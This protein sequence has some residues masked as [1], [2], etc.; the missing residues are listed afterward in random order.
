MTRIAVIGAGF[1]GTLL[2]LQSFYAAGVTT[3]PSP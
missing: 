2:A 3:S 1:S